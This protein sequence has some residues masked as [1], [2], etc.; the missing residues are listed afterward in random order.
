MVR[1]FASVLIYGLL[2][3]QVGCAE[4]SS[5]GLIATED[6]PAKASNLYQQGMAYT[7]GVEVEQSYAKGVSLFK[8]ST[9]YG[10]ADG[11]Y[12]VGMS[13]L[14]GRGV[15]QQYSEAARWLELAAKKEHMRAQY[16]LS[17]LYMNGRGVEEDKVWAAFLA[18]KAAD[19]GHPKAAF[20]VGVGYAKGLGVPADN[21]AAWYWFNQAARYRVEHADALRKK[22]RSRTSPQQRTAVISRMQPRTGARVDRA[23]AQYIQ[24]QLKQLG[25]L[26][27][28]VDGLWGRQSQAA[29]SRYTQQELLLT[30]LEINWNTLQLL[31]DAQ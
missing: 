18:N 20:D 4:L 26:K 11:A 14:T 29:F 9:H 10:S 15:Q 31:R 6:N 22:M 12:M 17:R 7:Q 1:L 13:Y 19:R 27:G 2:F 28:T 30:N 8:Q 16:Q 3:L 5:R 21:A 23:T 25:Y 24:Q